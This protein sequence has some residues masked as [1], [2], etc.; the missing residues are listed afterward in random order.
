MILFLDVISPEPKFVVID[1]NKTIESLHILDD[2]YKDEDYYPEGLKADS[3]SGGA[4]TSDTVSQE[5]DF[6]ANP[7]GGVE[8]HG[9]SSGR[10][11]NL[12]PKH[13]QL[14]DHYKGGFT[15]EDILNHM[16][17]YG[18]RD[19]KPFSEIIKEYEIF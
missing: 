10:T 3:A 4:S 13:K 1:N 8:Y 16:N 18:E 19:K 14:V 9:S 17:E 6:G 7:S 15:E 11:T 5:E 2:H 12:P